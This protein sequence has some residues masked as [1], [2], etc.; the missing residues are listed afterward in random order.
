MSFP[1]TLKY[2]VHLKGV[3]PEGAFPTEEDAQA[4]INL[5]QS[6]VGDDWPKDLIISDISVDLQ[7]AKERAEKAVALAKAI[8][9]ISEGI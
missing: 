5:L 9:A 4:Y 2:I 6:T 8:K 7:I 3:Q 1:S